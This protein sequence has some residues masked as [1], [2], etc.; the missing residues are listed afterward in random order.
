MS[1]K[2]NAKAGQVFIALRDSS[3][4]TG[5][6]NVGEKDEGKGYAKVIITNSPSIARQHY[7][8]P[9]NPPESADGIGNKIGINTISSKIK[10]SKLGMLTIRA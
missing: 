7:P 3:K 4:I 5:D 8:Y 6:I 9:N 2:I 1:G 10:V